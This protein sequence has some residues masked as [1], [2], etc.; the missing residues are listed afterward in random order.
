ME[1]SRRRMIKREGGV[2]EESERL[3]AKRARSTQIGT[4]RVETSRRLL[5]VDNTTSLT[6]WDSDMSEA[7]PMVSDNATLPQSLTEAECVPG[8]DLRQL[9]GT[10]KGLAWM[11]LERWLPPEF[12]DLKFAAT[13]RTFKNLRVKMSEVLAHIQTIQAALFVADTAAAIDPD[14]EGSGATTWSWT[15]AHT[16]ETRD[17]RL[18]LLAWHCVAV[19]VEELCELWGITGTDKAQHI[20][21]LLRERLGFGL[22]VR[23]TSFPPVLEGTAGRSVHG[24]GVAAPTT[25][26]N[27]SSYQRRAGLAWPAEIGLHRALVGFFEGLKDGHASCWL[28]EEAPGTG[29]CKI[30]ELPDWQGGAAAA[31]YV[32]QGHV[33]TA[34]D[35]SR[36]SKEARQ[37]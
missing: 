2:G 31:I 13:S 4:V 30:F 20:A 6:S 23:G 14:G 22:I 7:G 34:G 19:R 21:T 5:A 33:I 12:K 16:D 35:S 24:K 29:A 32:R 25:R 27:L 1:P 9:A 11:E 8:T 37:F 18:F 17:K 26:L 36:A 10:L 15:S 28:R 3:T